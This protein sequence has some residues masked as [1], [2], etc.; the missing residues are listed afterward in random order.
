M[1]VAILTPTFSK[2]SGPDRVVMNE[3]E[4]LTAK[5]DDVTIITFR[6]DFDSMLLQKKGINVEVLGMPKK[7]MAERLY[8]L[9]FFLDAAKALKIARKL[10]S[11]DEAISFLY[12]MTLPAMAARMKYGKK[13]RYTY[14]D[15][16]V[17]YPQLFD[18]IPEQVYMRIFSILTRLTTGNCDKAVSI[19]EFLSS[20]LK[21]HTGIQSEVKYV[22]IDHTTFNPRVSSIY[23]KEIA[24]LE[25]KH[26][27]K[28][29]VL[30]YVGRISPHKGIH[31]LLQAFKKVKEKIPEATLVIV[32]KHT[33]PKY[34]KDLQKTA[35]EIGGVI[36][37]G[38]VPDEELPAYYGICDIYCT[39]SM[40]E[41]FDIPLVEA[42][43][44]GKPAIVFDVG[45]HPEV[46]KKGTLVKAGN[47][48][49]FA[50]AIIKTLK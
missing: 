36:F 3:A 24:A 27:L 9:L 19:S 40:W 13:L 43:A 30:L 34:S 16:G 41:G 18:S 2:F 20:E 11:F 38:F 48:E 5:G 25:K 12:P 10:K 49:E 26:E 35:A 31:L 21:K 4:E 37:T 14:Y 23:K 1:K 28:K 32:G 17:A 15:V 22:R 6:T 33:F 44:C 29:P 7:P 50:A 46:L 42:N 39:A 47:A 45:S 8:R